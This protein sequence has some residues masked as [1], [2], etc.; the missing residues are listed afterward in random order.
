MRII[1]LVVGFLGFGVI[2]S[3]QSDDPLAELA[4]LGDAVASSGPEGGGSIRAKREVDPAVA[5]RQGDARN[6]EAKVEE[7][8]G[9]KF[10]VVALRL[11]I[12]KPAKQGVAE[13]KKDGMI[14]IVPKLKVDAGKVDM[15]DADTRLN[16]GA[17][18][19]QPGDKVLVRLGANKGKVY[20]A[21]YIERK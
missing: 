15:N 13:V 7:V 4:A 6:Y 17:F 19:L 16:A 20:E 8:K 10:P 21:E 9:G 2:A 11:K 12:M 1:F 3:A 5:Q 14:V 18:Y